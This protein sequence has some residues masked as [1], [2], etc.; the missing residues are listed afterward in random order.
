MCDPDLLPFLES[1]WI[2][3]LKTVAPRGVNLNMPADYSLLVERY[4]KGEADLRIMMACSAYHRVKTREGIK[5][6]IRKAKAEGKRV[7]RAPVNRHKRR[8]LVRP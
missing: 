7:G 3:S 4:R 6:G 1:Y 5:A 8:S 2:R